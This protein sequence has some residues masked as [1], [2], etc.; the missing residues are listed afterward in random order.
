MTAARTSLSL[1]VATLLL[2]LPAAALHAYRLEGLYEV[3]VPVASQDGAARQQAFSAALARVLVRVSADPGVIDIADALLEDAAQFVYRYEYRDDPP[4]GV[5]RTAARWLRVRFREQPLLEALGRAGIAT[6]G[7]ERPLTLLWLAGDAGGSREFLPSAGEDS[8][9]PA[10]RRHAERLGLPVT[11][12]LLDLEDLGRIEAGDVWLGFAGAIWKASERYTPDTVLS[13]CL[14]ATTGDARWALY[15]RDAPVQEWR[16]SGA[17][18]IEQGMVQLATLLGDRY[19]RSL[20]VEDEESI[21]PVRV[22]GLKDYGHYLDMLTYLESL[23]MASQVKVQRL[24]A[25]GVEFYVHTFLDATAV[26][27]AIELGNRL[28]PLAGTGEDGKHWWYRAR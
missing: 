25:Q 13:L 21:V 20:R 23:E 28:Q 7:S 9:A 17:A 2:L 27:R 16:T 8:P 22:T 11:L 14:E 18:R 12:P 24:S 1:S 10:I 4:P 15:A 5:E 19:G 3:V 6:W 26:R